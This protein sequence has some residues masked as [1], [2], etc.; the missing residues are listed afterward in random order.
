MVG[1]KYVALLSILS[2]N[3]GERAVNVLRTDE[4]KRNWLNLNYRIERIKILRIFL[5]I[6]KIEAITRVV[7]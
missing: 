1:A 7:A 5:I 3:R 6:V 4:M 2:N